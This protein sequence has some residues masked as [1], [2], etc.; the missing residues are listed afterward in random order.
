MQLFQLLPMGKSFRC[1]V[2]HFDQ[3]GKYMRSM[4]TKLP[5]TQTAAKQLNETERKK[6]MRRKKNE[7]K[8][9]TEEK[10]TEKKSTR[11]SLPRS[12]SIPRS[13][14]ASLSPSLAFCLFW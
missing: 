9:P 14:Y 3:S 8:K 2:A 4:Q 7:N 11:L 6:I 13:L 1:C 5:Q 10:E 12:L